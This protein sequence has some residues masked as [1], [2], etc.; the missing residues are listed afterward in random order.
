M[1]PTLTGSCLCK[2]IEYRI[3]G[4]LFMAAYCHCSMCRKAHGSAFRARALVRA[5]HFAWLK[6]ESLLTDYES[7]PGA[8]RKFCSRCGSPLVA[9]SDGHPAVLTLSLGT[10]DGD[11][12]VHPDAHWHVA[13]KASWFEITDDLPQYAEWPVSPSE[14]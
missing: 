11:P 12:A 2:A 14:N 10:I 8:H 1:E 13:S 6:G 9:Y 3:T 5:E 4:R 7:S